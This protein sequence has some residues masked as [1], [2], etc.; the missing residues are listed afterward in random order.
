[1]SWR[2]AGGSMELEVLIP[3]GTTAIVTLPGA[4]PVPAP[5]GRHRWT[6]PAPEAIP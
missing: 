2:L 4:A 3:P 6:G 5:P 1:V